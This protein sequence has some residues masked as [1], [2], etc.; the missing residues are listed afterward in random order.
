M[1][2]TYLQA[3]CTRWAGLFLALGLAS[4]AFAQSEPAPTAAKAAEPLAAAL[5]PN[6][7]PGLAWSALSPTQQLALAPLAASWPA[8]SLAHQNKWLALVQKYPEMAE[9]D[10]ARLHSRM[11]DWAALSPKNREIARLNFAETKKLSTD[12]RVA[13]WE[14]YQALPE[15]KKQELL[16]AAPKKA[17]GAAV[18]VKPVPSSKLAA[19]PVT[20]KTPEPVRA[21][22]NQR[23]TVDR[24][25]LLPQSQT[26]ENSVAAP[27][28]PTN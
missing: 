18:A 28:P 16:E 10:K 9:A 6:A 12:A 2:A 17:V 14:A 8:L 27:A 3:A 23:K 24:Y 7:E 21:V 19:V 1:T 26:T 13:N 20:R 22:V 4:G 15:S 11:A 25:T 5:P